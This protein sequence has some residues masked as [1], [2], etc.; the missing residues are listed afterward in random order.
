MDAADPLALDIDDRVFGMEFAVCAL[1][2][3]LYPD[4]PLMNWTSTPK[5]SRNFVS[6][7]I[8]SSVVPLFTM[9]IMMTALRSLVQI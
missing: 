7:R 9:I 3:L 6:S 2:G 8:C 1:V 5:L 4:D